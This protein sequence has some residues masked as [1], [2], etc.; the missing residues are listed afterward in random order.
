MFRGWIF[1]APSSGL[2]PTILESVHGAGHEGVHKSL[3]RLRAD[4]HVPNDRRVVQDFVCA[5][6]V[7]QRNKTEHL[8]PGGLL[9]PLEVPSSIWSDL[10]MDFIEALPKVNGKSVI[11][12]VV[13]HFSKAAHFIA[14]AHPYTA[15]S[16]ARAFFA[17]VVRL[18]GIPATIVSDRDP[19]FTSSFW[20]EL[21]RL[22]GVKLQFTSAFHPQSD[23]QSEVTNKIITM[24]LRCLT[25]DR[26]RNWLDWLPWAEF[27]YNSSYQQ[28]LKTS[29]F[30][31]VYGRPPPSIRSYD[32][33]DA[34]LPAV[35]KAMLDRDEFLA[36]VRDRLEQA[37]QHYKAVYDRRHRPVHYAPGQWVW[38]RLL[39]RPAASL[40][41]RGRGKLGPRFFGPFQVL[42]QIGDVAYKLRLPAGARIHDVFHVGL[43]KPFHGEP[44]TQVQPLPAV[45][46]GRVL[47][48]PEEVLRSRLARGHRELLVR[49]KGAPATETSWV[50]LVEFQQLFPKFQLEDELLVQGG[51]DVMVGLQYKR[52]NKSGLKE[53]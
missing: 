27:C 24:Y 51:R 1:I 47:V 29:P 6:S 10:A 18:H 52:R 26:P 28:S 41:V 2:L 33:G 7:C 32:H 50:S 39:H 42:E 5:C 35:E 30:E 15:V 14:L 49:W 38:L 34:R 48:E 25:G 43:L 9:Q 13:D 16:V 44:P 31:V 23:G 12:T 3:H 11:M 21:F 37:Q 36:E 20:R 46:H 4:F 19:V 40:D 45:R 17:E 53:A 8:Q 22:A